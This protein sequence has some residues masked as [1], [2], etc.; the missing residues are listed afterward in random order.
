ML[1]EESKLAA[2]RPD[3]QRQ[4]ADRSGKIPRLERSQGKEKSKGLKS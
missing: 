4:F 2:T 3:S 1:L